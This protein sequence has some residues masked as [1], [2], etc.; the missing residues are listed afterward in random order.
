MHFP[1][2]VFFIIVYRATPCAATISNIAREGGLS[3]NIAARRCECINCASL[4]PLGGGCAITIFANFHA[5]SSRAT[6]K[7]GERTQ[8]ARDAVET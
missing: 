8:I 3:H 6:N 2:I 5:A 7:K 4:P 1:Y